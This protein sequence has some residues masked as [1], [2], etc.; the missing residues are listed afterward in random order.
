MNCSKCKQKWDFF[1]I[2]DDYSLES[3]FFMV[4]G[5][6]WLSE[7]LDRVRFATCYTVRWDRMRIRLVEHE[8]LKAGTICI[9]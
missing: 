9:V 5:N 1:G 3:I 8:L 6:F 4:P 7:I 2:V